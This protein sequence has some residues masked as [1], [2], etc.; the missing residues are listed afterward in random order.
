MAVYG[1]VITH[2]TIPVN[3]ENDWHKFGPSS[4]VAHEQRVN[5]AYSADL[6]LPK[7]DKVNICV[8]CG[9][10]GHRKKHC[11]AGMGE[12]LSKEGIND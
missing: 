1:H 8:N 6:F 12:V 4:G 2:Y 11:T 3:F 10:T 7:K 9:T 5:A